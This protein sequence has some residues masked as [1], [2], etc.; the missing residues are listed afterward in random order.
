MVVVGV[1]PSTNMG[2]SY[3]STVSQAPGLKPVTLHGTTGYEFLGPQGSPIN[4]G[5][6]L[7]DP[8]AIEGLLTLG[9]GR[10]VYI[11]IAVT[12]SRPTAQALLTSFRAG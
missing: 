9:K 10:T 11:V 5:N 6:K 2:I 3:M 12:T 4:Q 8:H 1:L 7:S